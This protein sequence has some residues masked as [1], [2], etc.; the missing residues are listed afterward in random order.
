[1]HWD[2]LRLVSVVRLTSEHNTWSDASLQNVKSRLLK[3]VRPANVSTDSLPS[4]IIAEERLKSP[5]TPISLTPG[6]LVL[7][8]QLHGRESQFML[9]QITL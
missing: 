2:K 6:N 8:I 1:M 5:R 4:T 7:N 9:K 3:A